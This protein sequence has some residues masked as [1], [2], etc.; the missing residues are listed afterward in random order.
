MIAGMTR[1]DLTRRL[2]VHR[3]LSLTLGFVALAG[4][5]TF[6]YSAGSSENAQRRLRQ[7]LAQLKDRQDQLLD[8]R[9]QVQETVAGLA[10][11]RAQLVS[12]HVELRSLTEA[13]EQAKGQVAAAQRELAGITKALTEKRA[14]KSAAGRVQ[15]VER[16]NRPAPASGQPKGRPESKT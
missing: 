7:E 15:V 5:G 16:S 11:L 1:M 13:R 6:A 12:A 10:E 2:T 4:W 9:K 14:Q 3:A 8:E